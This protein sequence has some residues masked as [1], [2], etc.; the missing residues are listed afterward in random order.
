MGEMES[1]EISSQNCGPVNIELR[2][3]KGLGSMLDIFENRMVIR[4]SYGKGGRRISLRHA[5]VSGEIVG[6]VGGY[7]GR[8]SL[9]GAEVETSHDVAVRT[10]L[11]LLCE[12]R[13]SLLLH[14]SGLVRRDGV[15]LFIGPGGAGK[16][17]IATELNGGGT[18]LSVDRTV[19]SFEETGGPIVHS[20]PFSDTA[21]ILKGPLSGPIAGICRIEKA[22]EHGVRR[23]T[24]F[25]A[26][27]EL[28]EQVFAFSRDNK[29]VERTMAAIGRLVEEIP[30]FNL[31][32]AKDDGFWPLL[33]I[34]TRG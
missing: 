17:T 5:A 24:S 21:R 33:E 28:F 1:H 10:A 25:E 14:S 9:H 4:S 12:D 8:F 13:G 16:T 31:R 23:L 18:P 7:R 2:F 19:I 34:A 3:D 32:F 30:C 29:R 26:T 15:W 11:S 22:A 27:R 6:G 20:T